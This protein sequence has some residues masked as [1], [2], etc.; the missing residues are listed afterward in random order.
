MP[1][2][3]LLVLHAYGPCFLDAS[4]AFDRVVH[5]SL[6]KKLIDRNVPLVVVRI[7][8]HWHRQQTLCVKLGRTPRLSLLSQ[9]AS[10][11]AVYYRR[12]RLMA[13]SPVGL[14]YLIDI[15]A[16]YRFENDLLFN[17]SKSV[18]MVV[19]PRGRNVSTLLMFLN[20]V[21]LEHVDTVKYFGVLLSHDMKDDADMSRHL[22]SFY[23]RSNVIFC[24]F[25]NWSA[26]I[27][28]N[29]IKTYCEPYYSQLWVN[30]SKCSYN[31][32][33]VSY[34]NAYRRVLGYV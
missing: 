25:H 1:L 30:H 19:K 14:Q 4:K 7:L 22:R 28:V 20:G 16:N 34:N 27:K 2:V 17:R 11:R 15:C 3:T 12:L 13:P 6:F 21:A 5:W 31:K 8:V 23:A 10:G 29:C 33:R 32:L 24:K 9:M 18:C 26:S